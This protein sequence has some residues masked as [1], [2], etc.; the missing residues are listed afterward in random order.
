MFNLLKLR[1]LLNLYLKLTSEIG[2]DKDIHFL[3]RNC[4]DYQVYTIKP[5]TASLK[6]MVVLTA[7]NVLA[8]LW[9]NIELWPEIPYTSVG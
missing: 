6:R 3:W 7:F 5:C 8:F 1:N 9:E 2:R 4:H